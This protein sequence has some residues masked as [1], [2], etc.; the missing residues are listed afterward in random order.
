MKK[1]EN[2]AIEDFDAKARMQGLTYAQLQMQETLA[3]CGPRK[4]IPSNYMRAGS[5][6]K[7]REINKTI[8][9]QK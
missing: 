8:D 9:S 3:M 2:R 6:I 7:L 5:K 1:K 4:R